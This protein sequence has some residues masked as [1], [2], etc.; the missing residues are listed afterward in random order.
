MTKAV[1][2]AADQWGTRTTFFLAL[3]AAAIG[4]GNIW[5]F[6]YLAGE[7]GG[8]AFVISYVACL[9][10]VAVPLLIAEVVL[11]AQGGPGPIAAIHRAGDVSG[12]SRGWGLVGVLASVCGLLILSC[13]IVVAGWCMAY[14]DF[15]HTGVFSSAVAVEVGQ[16]FARYL[17]DPAPQ[18]YW[19]SL[20]L[21]MVAGT[22]VLGIRRGLA[23][24]VW[25]VVPLAVALLA[26]LIKFNFDNGDIEAAGDFLFTTRM[27]DFSPR[28]V[29]MALAH[30]L[31][32]L[33]IGVGTGVSY[34]AYA[35]GDIPPG[36]SVIAVALFDTLFGIL[37]G[38]AIFPVVFA[39]NL[40][41]AVGPGLLFISLPYAF[42]NL[43]QGELAGTV[44]FL[45]MTVAAL[46]SAVAIKEPIV[47]GLTRHLR[48]SRFTACLVVGAAVWLMAQ[49]VVVSL[50]PGNAFPSL[51]GGNLLGLF[52]ILTA[53]V[54]LP[55]VAFLLSL[56]VGWRLSPELLRQGLARESDRFFSLWYFLLRYIAPPTIAVL[57]LMSAL[58]ESGIV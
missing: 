48:L 7:Y 14:A 19:Q 30:A 47:A 44:F 28:T 37:A 35:A 32:T 55:V 24:L 23:L 26:F 52:D 12:L 56:L 42:G 18:M 3:S 6:S 41:P 53:G 31:F 5:R 57:L 4:L 40:E 11:G 22:L 27:A 46:G 16:H 39:N 34:G 13:L 17:S 50:G 29:L 1:V 15:M 54:L 21:L 20:F 43:Q 45:L 58:G 49:A 36:R 51:G 9:L 25:L 8:G 2:S 33:A 38:I 10:L